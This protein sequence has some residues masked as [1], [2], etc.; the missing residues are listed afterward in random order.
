MY[1]FVVNQ[2][3]V[4]WPENMSPDF[5]VGVYQLGRSQGFCDFSK[6]TRKQIAIIYQFS[7]LQGPCAMFAG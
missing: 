3:T 2:D 4:K 5:Q 7:K 1:L 6:V